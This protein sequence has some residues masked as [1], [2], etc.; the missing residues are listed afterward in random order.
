MSSLLRQTRALQFSAAATLMTA[1]ITALPLLAAD[2]FEESYYANQ[3]VQKFQKMGAESVGFY[4]NGSLDTSSFDFASYFSDTCYRPTDFD[5]PGCKEKFGPYANLK[6]TYESGALKTIVG[7]VSY[8]KDLAKLLPGS[9]GPPPSSSSSSSSM[10]SSASSASPVTETPSVS[11]SSSSST[12][13]MD[14][15]DRAS[16]VWKLCVN[17]FITREKSV[18]CYQRNIRLIME[19]TEAVDENLVY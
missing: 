4:S 14:R 3:I 5:M 17:K 9:Y 18:A 2:Q 8:L 16:Q 10:S 13:L 19:R 15:T 11:S 7:R 6:Q 1:A 12:D